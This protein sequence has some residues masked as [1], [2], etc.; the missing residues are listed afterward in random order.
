MIF[1]LQQR[2]QENLMILKSK[3]PQDEDTENDYME[4]VCYSILLFKKQCRETLFQSSKPKP[5]A[6]IHT[7]THTQCPVLLDNYLVLLPRIF[8]S[9]RPG[10]GCVLRATPNGT[11]TKAPVPGLIGYVCVCTCLCLRVCISK[12]FCLCK[13]GRE[14]VQVAATFLCVGADTV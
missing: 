2:K 3:L 4:R 10:G 5:P 8:T 12:Y 1:K 7:H 14:C 13:G 6:Y 9:L 11:W